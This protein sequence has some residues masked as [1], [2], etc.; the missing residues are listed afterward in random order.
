MGGFSHYGPHYGPGHK[1][2]SKD[3]SKD[4]SKDLI[5]AEIEILGKSLLGKDQ[6]S[7]IKSLLD[8]LREVF[9]FISGT[10]NHTYHTQ[11]HSKN[12]EG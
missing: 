8:M 2:L 9:A 3:S 10:H 12:I 5:L 6:G 1:D 7:R 11:S 4:S